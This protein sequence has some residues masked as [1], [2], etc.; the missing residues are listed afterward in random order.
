[1]KRL[2]QRKLLLVATVVAVL[3][4]TAAAVAATQSSSSGRHAY[5]NDVA[6]RLGI[7]PGALTNAM[8]GAA[9]DRINAAVAEGRLTPA[10]ANA[11]K[12]RVREGHGPFLA[13]GFHGGGR[14]RL[15]TVAAAYLGVTPDKLRSERRAG[16]SL[17][18]IAA[19]EHGKSVAGLKAAITE[20]VKTRLDMAVSHGRLTSA[21]AHQFLDRLPSRIE[22]FLQRT[23]VAPRL[24]EHH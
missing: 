8:R 12:Q 19:S 23:L 7:S 5:L 22:T 4:G 16:K 15:T 1:M 3:G 10:Q 18:Q 9:I 2:L 13:G 24:S 6:K 17:A 21:Q 11:L 14:A 20:A